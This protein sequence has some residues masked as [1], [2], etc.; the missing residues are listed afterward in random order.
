M[1]MASGRKTVTHWATS[2]AMTPRRKQLG[3]HDWRLP[4][5]PSTAV[6]VAGIVALTLTV[7]GCGQPNGEATSR[8]ETRST[9]Q[10]IETDGGSPDS[11]ALKQWSRADAIIQ[12]Q[13]HA[14][15]TVRPTHTG[16][17]IE[18]VAGSLATAPDD[19]S[20]S[21]TTLDFV[22]DYGVLL[23][24]PKEAAPSS[25][26]VLTPVGPPIPFYT[27]SSSG[28][29][30]PF[31]QHIGGFAVHHGIV[32]GRFVGNVLQKVSGRF[33]DPDSSPARGK[34]LACAVANDARDRFEKVPGIGAFP[35][36]WTPAPYVDFRTG[37]AFWRSGVKR[38]DAITCNWL[39]DL[40][41]PVGDPNLPTLKGGTP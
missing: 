5:Q 32:G 26:I 30:V 24:D 6:T 19:A 22:R 1:R 11:L 41:L 18:A 7:G 15:V 29:Y 20:L 16:F 25:P 17:L 38:L 14:E 33:Y 4:R 37:E 28:F 34:T 31:S 10:K 39:P 35:D 27:D 2:G 12:L 3:A 40:I 21:Q 36:A 9:G 8:S 23:R 13:Q